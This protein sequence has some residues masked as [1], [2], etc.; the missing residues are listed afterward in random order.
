MKAK[1]ELTPAGA[2]IKRAL[3]DKR[4]TQAEFCRRYEVNQQTFSSLCRSDKFPIKRRFVMRT[5][6]LRE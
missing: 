6:G 3:L 4:M 5:L 2:A 1:R